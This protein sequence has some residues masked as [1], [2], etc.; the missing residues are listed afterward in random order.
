M[1]L[2]DNIHALRINQED[3]HHAAWQAMPSADLS[4]GDVTI[5]V[6]YSGVNYKDALAVTGKGKILRR[7]PLNGGIDV[8]GIVVTS[9]SDHFDVGDQVLATGCDLSE[10]RDGGYSE[11]LHLDSDWTIPLPESMSMLEA[12]QIGTAGFTAALSLYRM[13][14]NGQTPQHG[15]VVIT[16]ASGGVGSLAINILTAAGYEVHAI[17]GKTE[18]FDWLHKLGAVS[19][20]DR[21]DLYLG[22]RPLE[23]P[24]WAGAID[25]VGGK[26]LAGLTR[27][28][29]PWGNIA[30]CGLAGGHELHTTVMPFILRGVSLLGI[31]SAQCP[32]PLRKQLWQRLATTWKPQQLQEIATTQLQRDDLFD[33]CEKMLAGNIHGR[34]TVQISS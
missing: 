18:Q 16:G 34:A 5:E 25:T 26:L 33:Y 13:E 31:N 1:S 6:H 29:Q 14:T 9:S 3:G 12:M 30:S 23:S 28:I 21:H 24:L 20:S 11:Y 10:T 27:V 4:P 15:P 17:S 7:F 8:A 22:D 32:T 2:P 19:C